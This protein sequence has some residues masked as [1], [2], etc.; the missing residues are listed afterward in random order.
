MNL[1]CFSC[2]YL[3]VQFW[4]FS[5]IILFKPVKAEIGFICVI[6]PCCFFLSSNHFPVK[7]PFCDSGVCLYRGGWGCEVGGGEGI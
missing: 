2:L 5:I 7:L 1:K 3:V 4:F 6:E